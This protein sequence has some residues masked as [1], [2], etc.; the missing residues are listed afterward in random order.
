M[1]KYLKSKECTEAI[2]FIIMFMPLILAI[3]N[4][5]NNKP[6]VIEEPAYI[7]EYQEQFGTAFKLARSFL[8]SEDIFTWNGNDY[9]TQFKEEL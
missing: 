5:I 7:W 6:I 2:L 4:K 8:G 9:T 3:S 1:I